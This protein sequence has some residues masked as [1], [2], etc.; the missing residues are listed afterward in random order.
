[1]IVTIMLGW[2]VVEFKL[3]KN[4]NKYTLKVFYLKGLQLLL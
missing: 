2:V 1:M 3:V 4:L